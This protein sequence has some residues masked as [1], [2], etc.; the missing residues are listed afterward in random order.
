MRMKSSA[1]SN[2]NNQS[3][4]AVCA[5]QANQRWG[6]TLAVAR[7]LA[8]QQSYDTDLDLSGL[9]RGSEAD[10]DRDPAGEKANTFG[11]SLGETVSSPVSISMIQPT[12]GAASLG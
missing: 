8:R 2:R 12:F 3:I 11:W 10:C 6:H 7:Q 9:G 4:D 1:I 5:R